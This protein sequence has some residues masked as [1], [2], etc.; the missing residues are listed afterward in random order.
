MTGRSGAGTARPVRAVPL[1]RAREIAKRA[2]RH[3]YYA[4]QGGGRVACP[5][6]RAEVHTRF[7]PGQ[8]PTAALRE[9]V[10]DHLTDGW[11][12]S[13]PHPLDQHPDQPTGQ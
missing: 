6:C 3:G 10:T 12:P 11:C 9:A 13:H 2:T 5:E 1:T 8:T 4:E 7:E